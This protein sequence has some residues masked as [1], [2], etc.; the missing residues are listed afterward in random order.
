MSHT[1]R[2]SAEPPRRFRHLKRGT[3]YEYIG[4]A[5]GQC[6]PSTI[7]DAIEGEEFVVY[8][9]TTDGSLWIRPRAEFWDGRFE[10]IVA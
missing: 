2:I 4:A 3:E 9:S 8:R 10:E 1:V 6:A 5:T 7:D